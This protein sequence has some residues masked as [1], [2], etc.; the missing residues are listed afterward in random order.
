MIDATRCAHGQLPGR[1]R[2]CDPIDPDKI[3][4]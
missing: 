3:P 4:F 1:C 2:D